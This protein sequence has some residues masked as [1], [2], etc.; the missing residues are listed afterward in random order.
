[1]RY[2]WRMAHPAAVILVAHGSRAEGTREAHLDLASELAR[3]LDAPVVAAFLELSD[4]D[5]PSAIDAAVAAGADRLVLVPYFL[6]HGNHTRRDIPVI[7]ADARGRHPG[8]EIAM[9]PP[10]GPDPRLVTIT[11]DR[12]RETLATGTTA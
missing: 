10:L 6:H 8:V 12:A 3:E 2:N 4:P 1:V 7:M 9:T 5:I 11:A